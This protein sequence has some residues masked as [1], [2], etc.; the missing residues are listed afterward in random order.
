MQM[1]FPPFFSPQFFGFHR[2]QQIQAQLW[3]NRPIT[4]VTSLKTLLGEV[5]TS[6]ALCVT[7]FFRK[8][9]AIEQ[10]ISGLWG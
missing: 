10:T 3:L 4:G 7:F 1:L 8:Q 5:P 2:K 6:H 9:H